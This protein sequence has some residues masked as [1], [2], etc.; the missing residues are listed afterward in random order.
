MP[1]SRWLALC[2][3]FS[4]LSLAAGCAR[5]AAP[6]G[7]GRPP[8]RPP[9]IV[10]AGD[11]LL[12]GRAERL[13]EEEGADAPFAGVADALREADLAVGNLECTVST[14]G[15]RAE[16]KYAFRAAPETVAALTE[17]GFDV[18]TLANN[19][20]ADFGR[21]ALVD[22][23][24]AL[25]EADI[26]VMGAGENAERAGE[27]VV[28]VA[29]EP[30]VRIAL[31]AFSNMQPTSFY[32]GA[33]RP[34]TNPAQP[35]AISESVA[36]AR[37]RADRVIVLFHWGQERS[38]TPS[39][40]QRELA[41]IAA[42][43]GADLVIGHHPHVLQGFERRGDALIAYSLGNFLFPSRG[44]SRMTMLLRYLPGRSG[45]ARV[46]VVPVV[47]E[48]FQPRLADADEA[49]DCVERLRALS[50][51][52]GEALPDQRGAIS[53]PAR[54]DSVDKADTSP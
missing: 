54:A 31:L 26:A 53:L 38:S 17:A 22:T 28:V 20:S 10:F 2:L 21:T 16:K 27:P 48:G 14:R 45:G 30:P 34:G 12:A 51:K 8:E 15:E 4:F 19:H 46:E 7:P 6:T 36:L 5:R 3:G 43:A 13:I 44:E 40:R 23:C 33:D 18:M 50:G 35:D 42:D 11:I 1:R 52:L 41:Y 32:A 24:R 9:A 39:A 47:I 49:A 25:R 37:T 29:G